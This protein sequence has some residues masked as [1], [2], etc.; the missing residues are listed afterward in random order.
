M[1]EQI[2][3]GTFWLS[4]CGVIAGILGL[5]IS[6]INK[7]KCSNVR[8]CCGAFDCTR[9]TDAEVEIEEKR[10]ELRIPDTPTKI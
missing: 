4:L 2:F 7:S 3:N 6:V 10:L 1:N 5:V 8:C 9:D